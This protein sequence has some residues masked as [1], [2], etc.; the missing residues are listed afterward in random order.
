MSGRAR[1]PRRWRH[2]VW[3]PV[4]PPG[5]RTGPPSTGATTDLEGRVD[6]LE[7]K[8]EVE[9]RRNDATALDLQYRSRF[10]SVIAGYEQVAY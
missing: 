10:G 9:K 7:M 2:D 6:T 3:P 5:S 1:T 8:L 4:S